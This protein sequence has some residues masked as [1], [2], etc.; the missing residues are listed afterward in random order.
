[1]LLLQALAAAAVVE[2][3]LYDALLCR[4]LGIR[5]P[6]ARLLRYSWVANALNNLVGLSG[7]TGSGI[8]YLWLCRE[9][10]D[11]KVAA[12]YAGTL[13]VSVSVG[14][15]VLSWVLLAWEPHP[16]LRLPAPAWLLQACLLALAAYLPVYLLLL[17][18][19]RLHSRFLGVLPALSVKARLGLVAISTLDWCLASLTA[20]ACLWAVGAAVPLTA[21]ATTFALASAVG[22][23]SMIPG[24]L[25]VF[26]GLLL[27]GL[28]GQGA[29][30][31][32][33]LGGVLVFRLV[34]FVVPWLL[35]I[36]FKKKILAFK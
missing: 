27:V 18:P 7:L 4:V 14:L 20:W 12:G 2:M 33:V 19:G 24:A 36:A 31:A 25:G 32:S 28:V 30:P 5:L 16:E 10:V 1:M 35:A 21:F 29:Q 23:F 3:V 6:P 9:G 26:D 13:M 11:S 22:L 8:R 15:S 34:Y 17:G